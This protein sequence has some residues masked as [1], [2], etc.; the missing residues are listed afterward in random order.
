VRAVLHVAGE[1][2]RTLRAS[3]IAFGALVPLLGYLGCARAF[4]RR[5]GAAALLLLALDPALVR[6]AETARPYAFAGAGVL[7][8]FVG[9]WRAVLALVVVRWMLGARSESPSSR[10]SMAFAAFA[11]G[12]T[13]LGLFSMLALGSNIVHERYLAL[14]R[15][16]VP[17]AGAWLIGRLRRAAGA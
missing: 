16:S 9:L 11:F 10:G 13:V 15:L 7:L 14:A 1:S 6:Q 8:A 12:L 2:E 5:A 4:G 17:I 3:G